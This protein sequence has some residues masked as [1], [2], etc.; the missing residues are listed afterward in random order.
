MAATFPFVKYDATRF[1]WNV[2]LKKGQSFLAFET[3]GIWQVFFR[4]TNRRAG[5]TDT[6]FR[7]PDAHPA[8]K[9]VLALIQASKEVR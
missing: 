7:V 6:L 5:Q 2:A 3:K 1:S 4:E 8:A 9:K